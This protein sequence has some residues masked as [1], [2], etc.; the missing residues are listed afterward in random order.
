M[1][2]IGAICHVEDCPFVHYY[3]LFL[4]II[5]RLFPIFGFVIFVQFLFLTVST[6]LLVLVLVI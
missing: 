6:V 1:L 2:L 5:A 3:F 4:L